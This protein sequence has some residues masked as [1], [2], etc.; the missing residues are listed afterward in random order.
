MLSLPIVKQSSPKGVR[1]EQWAIVLLL[2][3]FADLSAKVQK[4]IEF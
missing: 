1:V 4:N 2:S 3:C